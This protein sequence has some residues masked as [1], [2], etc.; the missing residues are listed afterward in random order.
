LGQVVLANFTNLNGL[1][2]VG[3]SSYKATATSGEPYYGQ[4]GISGFG[5]IRAGSL[6]Q[7][8]VDLTSELVELIAAQRNYQASAKALET[9]NSLSQTI[10]QLR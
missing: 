3:D 10:L 5:N 2:P 6:E 4:S 9:S 7:A 1:S 8:N